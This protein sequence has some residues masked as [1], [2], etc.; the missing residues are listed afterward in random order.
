[1][2]GYRTSGGGRVVWGQACR[3]D[4]DIVQAQAL[5]GGQGIVE[6]PVTHDIASLAFGGAVLPIRVAGSGREMTFRV[7]NVVDLGRKVLPT[8]PENFADHRLGGIDASHRLWIAAMHARIGAPDVPLDQWLYAVDVGALFAPRPVMLP[9]T[10]GRSAV[11]EAEYTITMTTTQ[12]PGLPASAEAAVEVDSDAY[13]AACADWPANVGCGYDGTPGNGFVLADDSGFGHLGGA[14]EYRVEVRRG[15]EFGLG[16]RVAAFPV[17]KDARIRFEAAGRTYTTAVEPGEGWR[18]IWSPDPVVL[19]AGVHTI[20][21]SA[22]P[23]GAG[24]AL[25]SLTLRRA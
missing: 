9:D 23:G 10:P 22:P 18:T 6:D 4:Y 7:G 16:Y 20:R 2:D 14:V 17:L 3:P 19:P 25:N 11:V 1:M 21:V 15:G 24:W 12:R 8:A 13:V 5:L